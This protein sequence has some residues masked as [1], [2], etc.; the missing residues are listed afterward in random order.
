VR[1]ALELSLTRVD[2][3]ELLLLETYVE[4]REARG[5]GI[6]DAALAFAEA[7]S[8]ILERRVTDLGARSGHG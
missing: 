1:I 3:R 2:G 5:Q 6:D 4:E 8:S 7:L